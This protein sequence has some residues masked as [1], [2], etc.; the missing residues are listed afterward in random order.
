M[1]EIYTLKHGAFI[2]HR[3]VL[4]EESG[5]V[6]MDM[7]IEFL[8]NEMAFEGWVALVQAV[9]CRTG[10]QFG[11]MRDDYFAKGMGPEPALQTWESWH[12]DAKGDRNK[13]PAFALS[14]GEA[15]NHKEKWASVAEASKALLGKVH[16]KGRLGTTRPPTAA[17]LHDKPSRTPPANTEAYRAFEHRFETVAVVICDEKSGAHGMRLGALRWGYGY[18]ILNRTGLPV[19]EKFEVSAVSEASPQ[20]INACKAWNATGRLQV[21]GIQTPLA[22]VLTTAQYVYKPGSKQEL[23]AGDSKASHVAT[24]QTVSAAGFSLAS[25]QTFEWADPTSTSDPDSKHTG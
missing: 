16:A 9:S 7:H 12:V 8:P 19:H 3:S 25:A 24:Q 20:W 15:R 21:P 6:G 11:D 23:Q 4:T 18:E 5:K 13:S 22:A 14:F 10:P 2:V 17:L 1:P